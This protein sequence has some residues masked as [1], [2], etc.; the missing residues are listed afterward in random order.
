[1]KLVPLDSKKII[2]PIKL[3]R[4]IETFS[5]IQFLLKLE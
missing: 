3:I 4:E 1:M 2:Y 5:L